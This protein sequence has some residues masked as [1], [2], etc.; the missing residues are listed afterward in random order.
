MLRLDV[1]GAA[2]GQPYAIPAD[3]PFAD[4]QAGRPEILHLGLRNPF[5]ASVDHADRRPLDG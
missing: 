5:R 4:G 3:N 2:A 1:A